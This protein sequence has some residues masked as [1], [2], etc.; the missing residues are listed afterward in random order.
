MFPF[1]LIDSKL[2]TFA[3]LS[4]WEAKGSDSIGNYESSRC[5]PTHASYIC[6]LTVKFSAF[7]VLLFV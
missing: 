4:I 2:V 5:D 7:K 1:L 3:A 6:A